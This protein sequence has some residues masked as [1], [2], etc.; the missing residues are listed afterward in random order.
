MRAQDNTARPIVVCLFLWLAVT[1][2]HYHWFGFGSVFIDED[3]CVFHNAAVWRK[4]PC[5]QS[6]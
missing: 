1:E 3:N 2:L 5:F 4:Q 6:L